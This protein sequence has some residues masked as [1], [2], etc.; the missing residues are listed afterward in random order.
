MRASLSLW[1]AWIFAACTVWAAGQMNAAAAS[2]ST[3]A[4]QAL[5]TV[6]ADESRAEPA[7][8]QGTAP[9][10]AALSPTEPP[11]PDSSPPARSRLDPDQDAY[12]GS[13]WARVR[14]GLSMA[15]LEGDRVSKWEQFYARQPEY[16]HRMVGR[17]GRYLYHIVEEVE[18]RQMPGIVDQD[19]T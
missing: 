9:A 5:A 11:A 8:A 16:V 15:D 4:V 13:L 3:A 6:T 10:A 2:S 19:Q 12:R 7:P 17:G 14:G 18:R 1:R